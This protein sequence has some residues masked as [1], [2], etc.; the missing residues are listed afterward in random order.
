MTNGMM[1]GAPAF[2]VQPTAGAPMQQAPV[3]QDRQNFSPIPGVTVVDAR[4]N[5]APL[6][7]V[8]SKEKAGKSSL[9]TTLVNWPTQGMDPLILAWDKTGPDSCIRLGYR[10]HAIRVAEQP[11]KT[12]WD[13]ARTVLDNLEKNS[14]ALR[15]RYGVIVTDC[16]S[17]MVDRLHEDARRF[18]P[19]P[20]PQSHFG[21]ALMQAKEW[22]NRIVDLGMPCIFLAWLREPEMTEVKGPGGQKVKKF[23]PGGANILG[24]TRASLAGRAHHILYLEKQKTGVGTQGADEEGYTRLIHT[25]P[26]ENIDCHGRYSHVLPEPAPAHLG[27]I[28]S[29][30]TGAGPYAPA[31][32]LAPAGPQNGGR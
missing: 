2:A 5:T 31:P 26:Y 1:Q 20:N 18:S 30:I 8:I 32:Q 29:Q 9:A 21:D 11:G 16:A 24:G 27:W 7:L 28:L 22:I 4:S 12:H 3:T 25:R 13:R 14:L 23:T 17:M 6:L 19:N 15:G 10:P